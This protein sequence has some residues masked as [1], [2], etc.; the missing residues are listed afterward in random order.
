VPEPMRLKPAPATV[1]LEMLAL[2]FPVFV[3]VTCLELDDATVALPKLTLVGFAVSCTTA[4]SPAPVK[5]M[6]IDELEALLVTVIAPVTLLAA[7]GLNAA[8]K[9]ALA[10]G[11]RVRGSVSPEI[12]TVATE[13]A[14]PET[15]R[16]AVPEFARRI[17]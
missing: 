2:T 6:G 8:V 14:S 10:P 1:A 13:G 15:V 17:V 16:L 12:L 7:A 9:F 11:A 5:L 4:A 3:T